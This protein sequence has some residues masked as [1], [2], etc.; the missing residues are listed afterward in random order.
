MPN[1]GYKVEP[2]GVGWVAGVSF[3][4]EVTD[5]GVWIKR[6]N[7]GFDP[8]VGQGLTGRDV[9]D[10]FIWDHDCNLKVGAFK[11][12]KDFWICIIDLDSFG[13]ETFD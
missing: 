8:L 2:S 9:V 11:S 3:N 10:E 6:Y 12:F 13:F 7:I 5:H 4:K 1:I